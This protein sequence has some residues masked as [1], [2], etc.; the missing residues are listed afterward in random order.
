MTPQLVDGTLYFSS[1][2]SAAKTRSWY[3]KQLKTLSYKQSFGDH[4]KTVSTY[5]TY[6]NGYLG[7]PTQAPDINLGFVPQGNTTAFKLKVDYII[8]PP[9]PKDSYLTTDIVKVVLSNGT[10][11]KTITDPSWITHVVKQINGLEMSTMSMVSGGTVSI[12]ANGKPPENIT[13]VL[14][15]V[16]R[17]GGCQVYLSNGWFGRVGQEKRSGL[18][19]YDRARQSDTIR[20]HE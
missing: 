1:N 8:M 16:S 6:S 5:V 9:R 2:D 10:K 12:S 17:E 3:E 15:E 7:D 19:N 14:R 20:F 4:G 11:S 13:S 18:E